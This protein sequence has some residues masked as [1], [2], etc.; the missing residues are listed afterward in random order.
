MEHESDGDANCNWCAQNNPQRVGKG[1][2]RFGY[3]RTSGSHPD[4]SIIKIGQNTEKSPG[5]LRRLAI[6]Q[7]P[8]EKHQLKRV[9]KTLKG[10]IIIIIWDFEIEMNE[11]ILRRQWDLI[12]INKKKKDRVSLLTLLIWP[13]CWFCLSGQFVDFADLTNQWVKINENKIIA[14]YLDFVRELEKLWNMKV[15]LVKSWRPYLSGTQRL[16]FQ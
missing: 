6:S 11:P 3:K 14:K 10:V 9:W 7:T 12:L 13:V 15:I 5:D 4:C 8:V 16:P 1:T 2:G